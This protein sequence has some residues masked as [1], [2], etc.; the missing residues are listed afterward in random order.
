MHSAS[1]RIVLALVLL[2]PLEAA[3]QGRTTRF[4]TAL[5]SRADVRAALA[6]LESGFPAQVEEW[7]RIAEIQGKSE[8]EQ[9][10]GALV[11]QAMEAEG[12]D[13]ST[14]SIGN[15]IGKRKGT[16][17][18]PTI[19]FAAH[20][21]IVHPLGTDLKVRRDGD[22][23]RSPGIFDNSASVA[24]MLAVIRAL[25]GARIQT[26][27]DLIFIGTTQEELGLH[28]MDYWLEHNPRPDMLVAMD[29][30]VGPISYGALGIYWSRYHF[31]SS[32]SHT[33]TSRGRPTP[34]KA[35]AEAI[36]R[37]YAIDPPTLPDGAIYNIGQIHGGNIFNG[38]P[39]ELYFT[40][41]LRSPD[42]ALLDSLDRLIDQQVAE[43]ARTHGV[44]WRKEIVQK[45]RAGGT[46]AMLADRRKHPLVETAIDIYRH[47][48]FELPA[49]REAVPSGSTDANVGVVRGIPSIAVGRAYGG[50]QHTLHEWSHWPSALPA[51]KMV[52]LLAVAMAD[53]PRDGSSTIIP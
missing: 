11:R 13:V 49:G 12:L 14:D 23:L 32:G 48:G 34:V 7:I 9:E 46:S 44:E 2:L 8:H 36:N 52:L 50:N 30:G 16:G 33:L 15:V 27:G 18:G 28:G 21:D 19:V 22:T 3:A 43:A 39:E 35:L 37:I 6:H 29:G 42:P 4:N 26:R 31:A 5:V 20:M 1:A 53:G 25:N 45:N 24:N 51:T 38:I 40:M 41:D 17:G 10:R 47:V